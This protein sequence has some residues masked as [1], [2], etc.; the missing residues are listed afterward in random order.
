MPKSFWISGFFFPQSFLTA[1]L[2]THSRKYNLAI[3]MLKFDFEV[4]S[5][6]LIQKR[7]YEK[8]QEGQT[9]NIFDGINSP[10]DGT[11][12]HG[13]FLEAGKWNQAKG[14]LI[15]PD[16]GELETM[17]PIVWMKPCEKIEVGNR[18]EAPLYKTPVRAG[19]LSTT[20]HSTNF[21]LSVLLNS[22]KPPSFWILRGTALVTLLTD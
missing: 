11:Y 9:E 2:Q 19:V 6:T 7:I 13:L 14:G 10:E 16:I 17:M 18:Y 22:E 8:R 12:V 15:D 3:D 5:T 4:M 1:V 21:I 20:G